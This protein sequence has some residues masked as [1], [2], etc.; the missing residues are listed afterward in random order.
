MPGERKLKRRE[1]EGRKK[2]IHRAASLKLASARL[3]HC[4]VA[5]Q[6]T[7]G[8]RRARWRQWMVPCSTND[9]VKGNGSNAQ[10]SSADR[11]SYGALA[12]TFVLRLLSA[13]TTSQPKNPFGQLFERIVP[14]H[15]IV[16][17]GARMASVVSSRASWISCLMVTWKLSS[18]RIGRDKRISHPVISRFLKK[19]INEKFFKNHCKRRT[20]RN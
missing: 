2:K 1:E 20:K 9:F 17:W 15:Y 12:S 19:D 14:T 3:W 8:W 7:P 4:F 6:Q 16:L 18:R 13:T 11:H 10:E 5:S